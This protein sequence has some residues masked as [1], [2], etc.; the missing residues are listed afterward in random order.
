MVDHRRLSA[1]VRNI[2]EYRRIDQQEIDAFKAN[3]TE[4][5]IAL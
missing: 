5:N 4:A 3:L 1:D 2:M